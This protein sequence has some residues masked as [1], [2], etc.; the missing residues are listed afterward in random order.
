MGTGVPLPSDQ[1]HRDF[2]AV[3]SESLEEECLEPRGSRRLPHF[4]QLDMQVQKDFSIGP[5][6][7][8]LIASVLNVLNT[9]I[10]LG[11]N[12]NAGTR[13]ITGPDGNPAGFNVDLQVMDWA[14]VLARRT[15]KEGWSVYGVHAGGFDDSCLR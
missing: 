8:G 10:P 9:E 4:H 13:A 6:K 2:L 1:A 7:A 12:G 14:S 11:I 5:V 15:K 3:V